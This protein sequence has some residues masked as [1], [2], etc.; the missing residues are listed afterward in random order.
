MCVYV[1]VFIY[2]KTKV[3]Y[4]GLNG[5]EQSSGCK[6][7]KDSQRYVGHTFHIFTFLVSYTL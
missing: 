1:C 4:S 3:G 6:N 5:T 7:P 2:L